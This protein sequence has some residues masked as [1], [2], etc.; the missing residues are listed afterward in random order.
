MKLV[1]ETGTSCRPSRI[2]GLGLG[3]ILFLAFVVPAFEL[4]EVDGVGGEQL[5]DE[6]LNLSFVTRLGGADEIVVGDGEVGHHALEDRGVLIGEV[7]RR[8]APRH[9]RFLHLLAMFIGA[10]EEEQI[11]PGKAL[12]AGVHIAHRAG[13]NVAD[14]RLVVH[15]ENGRGDVS[16]IGHTAIVRGKMEIGRTAPACLPFDDD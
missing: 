3:V 9:G 5:R 8:N 6:G 13:V 11:V 16:R 12:E 15:I 1:R 14:V 4:A 7:L 10:R 2:L